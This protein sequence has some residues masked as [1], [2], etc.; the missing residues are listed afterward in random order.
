MV[1]WF[2][3]LFYFYQILKALKLGY[4][5]LFRRFVIPKVRLIRRFVIPKVR[6]SEVHYSE[7]SLFRRFVNPK[8]K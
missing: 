2:K 8:R 6:Y 5:L 3:I 4:S 1:Y 7:D